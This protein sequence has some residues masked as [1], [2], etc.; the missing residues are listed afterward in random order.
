MNNNLPLLPTLILEN[1]FSQSDL[2]FITIKVENNSKMIPSVQSWPGPTQGKTLS[3]RYFWKWQDHNDISTIINQ[4][5][6][7]VVSSNMMSPAPFILESFIPY[8]IH[9]DYG[10]FG[11]GLEL[12]E[13]EIPFYLVIIPLLTCDAKTI[14]LKQYGEYCHFV[15]Y[16]EKNDPLPLVDQMTE[17]E[18]QK[19]FN[20]CWP[21]ERPYVSIQ[22]IFK[23]VAGSVLL[24]DIRYFHASDNFLKNNLDVKK[25]I[26]L[27][28]KIKKDKFLSVQQD[29]VA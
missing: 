10:W 14:I 28:T 18:Y 3:H 23:W 7:D 9:N 5:L 16:K 8:E 11:N 19:Y 2:D 20:H 1:K 12:S 27:M 29:L 26:T 13:D 17:E 24:C 4:A 6:P 25:C 21:Q 15:N 22:N